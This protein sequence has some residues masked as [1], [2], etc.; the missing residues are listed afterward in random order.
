[1]ILSIS[2]CTM[3]IANLLPNQSIVSDIYADYYYYSS[4]FDGQRS[5]Q[6]KDYFAS[7]KASTIQYVCRKWG[8]NARVFTQTLAHGNSRTEIRFKKT[9][10][11]DKQNRVKME[12]KTTAQKMRSTDGLTLPRAYRAPGVATLRSSG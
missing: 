2:V 5:G 8:I 11:E 6:N 4:D 9:E 3:H 12:R 10:E 7:R 1:M